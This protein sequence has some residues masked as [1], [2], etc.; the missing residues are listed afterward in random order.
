V[1]LNN[2]KGNVKIL[3]T[4]KWVDMSFKGRDNIN[5]NPSL[6]ATISAVTN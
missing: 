5:K 4:S 2:S 3:K 6:A 1:P